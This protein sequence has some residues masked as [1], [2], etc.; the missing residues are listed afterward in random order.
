MS[1]LSVLRLAERVLGVLFLLCY[2]YQLYYLLVPLL[3]RHGVLRS[4]EKPLPPLR[5]ASG[6]TGT[7]GGDLIPPS[8]ETAPTDAAARYAIL[9]CARN[10]QNVI[11]PLLESI[12]AQ[13]HPGKIEVFVAADNCTDATAAVARSFGATVYERFDSRRVGKGYAL[14]WLLEKMQQRG[15]TAFDGYFVF[16]A[17]NLLRRDYVRQMDR[18]FRAGYPIVTGYRNSKNFADNWISAGYALWFLREA[19]YLNHARALCGTGCAVSGTGF[20]FSGE[21]LRQLGGWRFFLLTEDIQFSVE[22]ALHGLKIGYCPDAVFYDEQPTDFAQSWRQRLRWSRGYLQVCG[23][24]G[25]RLLA[26]ALHVST[27]CADL[28]LSI[29]P[30]VVLTLTGGA[31]QLAEAVLGL[32]PGAGLWQAFLPLLRGLG[33]TSLM[34]LALGALTMCSQW[35]CI[36]ATPVQKLRYTVTFP[37]FMLTYLP[38]SVASLFGKVEWKPIRHSVSVPLE[39]LT[40]QTGGTDDKKMSVG[41]CNTGRYGL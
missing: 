20:L 14:A 17:D 11:G 31:V 24:Y 9:I 18:T 22:A 1:A 2:G 15:H 28:L 7:F 27:T 34:L 39:R 37:L 36:A 12:R 3:C 29:L 30:A 8:R 5:E 25:G 33:S 26:G 10:E 32:V 6:G 41:A 4:R 35:R 13:D 40:A 38:V 19:E 21:A 16:D 23:R